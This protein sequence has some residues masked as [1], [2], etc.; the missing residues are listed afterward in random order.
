MKN[1]ASKLDATGPNPSSVWGGQDASRPQAAGPNPPTHRTR[2]ITVV[3]FAPLSGTAAISVAGEPSM[4]AS[5][6]A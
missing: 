6:R 1:Q 4:I 5:I 2:G 3:V